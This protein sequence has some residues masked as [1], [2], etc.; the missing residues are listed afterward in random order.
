[1]TLSD[2]QSDVLSRLEENLPTAPEFPGPTFWNMVGEVYPQIVYGMFEAT[3]LTGTTQAVNQPFTITPNTNFFTNPKG[4]IAALRLKAP[5]PIRKVT[6]KGLDDMT[7]NWEQ[8]T[9]GSQIV[10]WFPLG[11]SGFGI[12]PAL[13]V[14]AIVIIDW[15]QSPVNAPRPY[16]A[17]L[18]VP[19]AP[20]FTDGFSQYGAAACRAKEA[21]SEAEEAAVVYQEYLSAMKSLS[22][23]QDRLDSLKLSGAYGGQVMTNPRST[24]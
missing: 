18:G 5:Y 17:A 11:T 13:S 23:W 22:L 10:S 24:V 14:E 2:L 1:V 20:Q 9:P 4:M 7:P 12:Y 19:F 15:I 8:A 6:L 16:S 3:L 21:G